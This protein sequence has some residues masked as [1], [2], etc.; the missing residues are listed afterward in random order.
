VAVIFRFLFL[1][2]S[3]LPQSF[4]DKSK[5]I[6]LARLELVAKLGRSMLRPYTRFLATGLG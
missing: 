6:G 2:Q 5:S 1:Q 4:E 3:E